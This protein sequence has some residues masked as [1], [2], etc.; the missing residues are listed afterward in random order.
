MFYW[1]TDPVVQ[2]WN[3]FA[4]NERHYLEKISGRNIS[5]WIRIRTLPVSGSEKNSF[6]STT[7]LETTKN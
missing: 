6:V 2:I 3:T 4:S 1:K 5:L 7:M